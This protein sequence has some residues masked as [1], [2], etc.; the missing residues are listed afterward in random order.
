MP[1]LSADSLG[2]FARS[3]PV[4]GDYVAAWRDDPAVPAP[5]REELRGL[6]SNPAFRQ[7]QGGK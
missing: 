2:S 3:H 5:I 6:L 4:A 1:T 7:E